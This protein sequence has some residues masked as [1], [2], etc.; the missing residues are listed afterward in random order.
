M[1]HNPDF[2]TTI[3]PLGGTTDIASETLDRLRRIL[4]AEG[5]GRSASDKPERTLWVVAA[6]NRPEDWPCFWDQVRP[7]DA[8]AVLTAGAAPSEA[9][10]APEG[11]V[12]L[13]AMLREVLPGLLVVPCDP[14]RGIGIDRLCIWSR[15]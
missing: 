7:G 6:T 8:I 4:G 14:E 10:A 5:G 15:G 3:A 1:M 12:L 13:V 2:A 11:A 9:D